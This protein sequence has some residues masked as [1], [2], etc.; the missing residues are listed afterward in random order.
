MKKR[1]FAYIAAA[2]AAISCASTA[3]V[4]TV[5]YDDGLYYT[6]PAAQAV[7]VESEDMDNLLAETK[8]APSYIISSGDTLVVPPGKTIVLEIPRQNTYTWYNSPLAYDYYWGY[9]RHW[10]PW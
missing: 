4:Q 8:Q 2:L 9:Y 1:F 10:D 6:K 5:S 7:T 3:Q